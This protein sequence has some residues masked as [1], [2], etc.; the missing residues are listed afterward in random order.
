MLCGH[1]HGGQVGFELGP[2]RYSLARVAYP[3]WAGLYQEPRADGQGRQFLYVNR[4]LGTVGPPLRLGI[5]PEITLL[6]LRR[7]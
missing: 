6:T 1:T 5:R 3:R 7:A 4:G 2:L